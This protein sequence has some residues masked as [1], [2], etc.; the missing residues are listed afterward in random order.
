MDVA[1][2]LQRLARF[3][4]ALDMYEEAATRFA[5]ELNA[6][7]RVDVSL[8][9]ER[10]RKEVGSIAVTAN[11]DAD[12]TLDGH[13]RG[14]LPLSLPIRVLP[15]RHLV[16]VEKLGYSPFERSVEVVAGATVAVEARLEPLKG[17]GVLRVEDN[18]LEGGAVFVDGFRVGVVPWEGT[19]ATGRHVVRTRLAQRGSAPTEIFILQGQA[20]LARPAS[21]ELGGIVH[22]VAEPPSAAI[23]ID[24]VVVGRGRWTGNLPRGP[25]DITA[26][27]AGYVPQSARVMVSDTAEQVAITLTKDLRD[28]RWR[29]P[30][31]G[32]VVVGGFA[33]LAATGSINFD[34]R[35]GRDGTYVGPF[36]GARVGYRLRAG[37]AP[38][39]SLGFLSVRSGFQRTYDCGQRGSELCRS[40]PL[41]VTYVVAHDAWLRGLVAS[42]GG[43]WV[44]KFGRLEGISRVAGGV[45]A[46]R[47]S[48]DATGS[49]HIAA[50]K[51]VAILVLNDTVVWPSLAPFGYAELGL[52]L[53][54]GAWEIG[55]A[56]GG[57]AFP[58]SGPSLQQGQV[59]V[60]RAQPCTTLASQN[61][62]CAPSTRILVH[63]RAHGPFLLA[64]PQV[65][66]SVR[67]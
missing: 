66:V 21:R 30:P 31:P 43:S 47:S 41:P 55:A 65:S 56:M 35:G 6:A 46:A 19:V 44:R 8:E 60:V 40:D 62:A 26:F 11:V 57:A 61:V 54:I 18:A 64:L 16:R 34:E 24:G 4:E 33:A 20:A 39:A 5:A 7:D 51:P 50:E 3:D 14:V 17:M 23:T 1:I 36:V 12:V 45:M 48:D 59:D 9:I 10:L 28:P 52:A 22:L 2:C 25:H 37:F 67:L 53:P 63:D 32:R 58:A 27:D 49:A 42:L 38:E 29:K 15:R 13:R